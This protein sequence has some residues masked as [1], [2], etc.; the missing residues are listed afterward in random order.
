MDYESTRIFTFEGRITRKQFLINQVLIFCIT[1]T[2]I[3]FS[4][5]MIGA[6]AGALRL[7]K[8]MILQLIPI[9]SICGGM[10]SYFLM[11]INAHK[12]ARDIKS[13]HVSWWLTIGLITPV[14]HTFVFLWLLFTPGR[15]SSV[16][17]TDA[18]LA[19]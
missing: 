8:K 4:A 10:L 12:R 9:L 17:D 2:A 14:V 5:G 7:E 13:G 6:V 16:T 11:M 1:F 15:S 3:I 18:L 19:A